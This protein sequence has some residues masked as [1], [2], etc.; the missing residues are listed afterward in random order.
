MK[1]LI[2]KSTNPYVNLA[3]EEYMFSNCSDDVFMLWQN[4]PTVVI[5]KNQNAYAEIN[6]EYVKNNNIHDFDFT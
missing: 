5:G 2:L 4:E 1:F 6:T 3:T